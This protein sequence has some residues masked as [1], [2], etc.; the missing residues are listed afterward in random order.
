MIFVYVIEGKA[1]G[2]RYVGITNNLLRRLGEHRGKE[3]KA[4]QIL[5]QFQLLHSERFPDYTTAR[6]RE[7][8]LKSGQGREW[9]NSLYSRSR[10]ASGGQG[11]ARV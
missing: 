7:K 9:L 4:G 8:F 5:G 3:S 1:A 6:A 10:P 11:C 2:K